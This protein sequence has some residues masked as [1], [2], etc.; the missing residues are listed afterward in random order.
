[1]IGVLQCNE[2]GGGLRN[3]AK[4]ADLYMDCGGWVKF[5]DVASC[6]GEEVGLMIHVGLSLTTDPVQIAVIASAGQSGAFVQSA[7]P[8]LQA[9][10][11]TFE[12]LEDLAQARAVAEG[13]SLAPGA[14]LGAIAGYTQILPKGASSG[15]V[16]ARA[17]ARVITNRSPKVGSPKGWPVSATQTSECMNIGAARPHGTAGSA[18]QHS[19]PPRQ[20]V[21]R[22]HR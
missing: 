17:V 15:D 14:G 1:M 3:A 13:C 9:A 8:E 18:P 12:T 6:L 19:A 2:A 10:I 5:A 16:L 22:W 7:E 20:R 4:H 11:K 21:C